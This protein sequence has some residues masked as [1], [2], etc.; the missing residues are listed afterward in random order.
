MPLI[1]TFRLPVQIHTRSANAK[2]LDEIAHTNPLW[3]HPSDAAKLGVETGDLVRVETAHRPLRREGLGDRGHPAGRR[4]LQPPHGPLEDS[5]TPGQRQMMATVSL[6]REG[7][8]LDAPAREGR[9]ALR[10]RGRRH[11]AHLVDGRRRPPEPDVPGAARP[12]LR[13]ALLAPG[14]AGEEGRPGRPLRRRRRSTPRRPARPTRSGCRAPGPRS[15][16]RP[17]AR[18][19]PTGCCGRSSRAARPTSCPDGRSPA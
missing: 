2:W 16:T 15:C 5:A 6:K 9:R 17:T 12:H 4:R 18:G 13:H 19:G 3:L 7:T 1:P 11:V 14:G 8:S 10:L